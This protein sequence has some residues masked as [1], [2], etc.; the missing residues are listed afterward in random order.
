MAT[1]KLSS[2]KLSSVKLSSVKLSSVKAKKSLLLRL[3]Y[4]RSS[5]RWSS[6]D[7]LTPGLDS[8]FPCSPSSPC[9]CTDSLT[10][11]LA[12]SVIKK[13]VDKLGLLADRIE[14]VNSALSLVVAE[15]HK[16]LDHSFLASQEHLTD[17][18]ANLN[19]EAAYKMVTAMDVHAQYVEAVEE[20]VRAEEVICIDL[21]RRGETLAGQAETAFSEDVWEDVSDPGDK[22]VIR[23][24]RRGEALA[25]EEDGGFGE[26]SGGKVDEL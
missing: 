6:C 25:R 7:C 3:K 14:R 11:K 15:S 1:V 18:V 2:V 5:L 16:I 19:Y 23:L 9:H 22:Q 24:L 10:E 21:R 17:H 12:H 20:L 13:N 4:R 8:P 26:V